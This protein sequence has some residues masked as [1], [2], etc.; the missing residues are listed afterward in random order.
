MDLL[1]QS[2]RLARL[3]VGGLLADTVGIRAVYYLGGVL[4]LL[5]ATIGFAA[6]R[7]P[8]P[9]RPRALARGNPPESGLSNG[10][11]RVSSPMRSSVGG[12]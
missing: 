3:G 6:S 2:G 7:T 8:A 4:L 10:Q 1:W 9:S 11:A 12:A 5:A